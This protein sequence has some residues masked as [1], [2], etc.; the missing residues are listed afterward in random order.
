MEPTFVSEQTVTL[1]EFLAWLARERGAGKREFIGGRIVVNPPAGWPHADIGA[2]LLL[3]LREWA[4]RTS[5]GVVLDS[6]AGYL[7]PTGDLVEPDVSFIGKARWDAGPR[8]AAGEHIRIVPDLMVEI[9][10]SNRPRDLV[11]KK[12]I[13]EASAVREYWLPDPDARSIIVFR[14]SGTAFAAP[15]TFGPAL[16]LRSEILPGFELLVGDLFQSP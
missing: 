3:R 8:P 12:S 14:R 13:Y 9:L 15:E 1:S 11:E 2:E 7:L 6:S 5:S 16:V 10:S 4:R